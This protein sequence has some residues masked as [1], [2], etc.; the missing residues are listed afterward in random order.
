MPLERAMR[1]QSH[2]RRDFTYTLETVNKPLA[3]PL[4]NFLF[5][6]KR[7]YCE[8]FASAM[9]VMLRSLGIPA[10]V[11]TGFQSGY[12]NQVSGLYVIRASD[13]HAW[14]EGWIDGLGWMSFDPTPVGGTPPGSGLLARINMYFDAADSAWQQWVLAYD[15]GH[16]AALVARFESGLKTWNRPK[17]KTPRL[18]S[19]GLRALAVL[20]LIVAA[21][22]GVFVV[23]RLWRA[24]QRRRQVRR[25]CR[26]G[27]SASDASVLYRH[28][29]EG[30]S[31]RGF[32]KPAWFTPLE[33]ARHLP[34]GEGERITRFTVLYNAARFGG[35]AAATEQLAELLRLNG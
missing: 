6:S 31:K 14:V 32:E 16:Q 12:Y 27:G 30:L 33:F 25:I 34:A 26:E 1:I 22:V 8:Y 10:R 28:M 7:G 5:V 29:L 19:P 11:A 23:P 24:W 13:A 35:S 15:L 4:S 2:L 9:A 3:D 17:L 18:P 20:L 21:V